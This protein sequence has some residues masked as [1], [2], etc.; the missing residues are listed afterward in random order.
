MWS[1]STNIIG[2]DEALNKLLEDWENAMQSGTCYQQP[3]TCGKQP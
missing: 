1:S 2:N 3:C